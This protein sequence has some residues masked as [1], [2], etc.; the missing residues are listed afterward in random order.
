MQTFVLLQLQKVQPLAYAHPR[1]VHHYGQIFATTHCVRVPKVPQNAY[2]AVTKCVIIM[3][4]IGNRIFATHCS[5]DSAL[6]G[7][8]VVGLGCCPC[9]PGYLC[10]SN[11]QIWKIF[12]FWSSTKHLSWNSTAHFALGKTTER[13]QMLPKQ[14]SSTERKLHMSF[15]DC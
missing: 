9:C 6:G 2:E 15:T 14:N 10:K 4:R 8:P 12:K 5:S 7:S 11:V 1:V 3:I 13:E